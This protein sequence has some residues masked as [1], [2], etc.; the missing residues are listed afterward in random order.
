MVEW[1]EIAHA[2]LTAQKLQRKSIPLIVGSCKDEITF[3]EKTH[4]VS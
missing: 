2:D 3:R 1:W 4:E